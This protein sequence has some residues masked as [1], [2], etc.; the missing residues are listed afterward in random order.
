MRGRAFTLVEMLIAT[1]MVAILTLLLLA[2]ALGAIGAA[3]TLRCQN[4]LR[5][6][7]A[8][9]TQ[10]MDATRG[11]WPPILTTEVP[12]NLFGRIEAETGLIMAPARP[13]ADWGQPGP[14]WSIVLWPYLKSLDV[15][16]CPADPKAG[17]RG[18]DVVAPA[19]VHNVALLGAPPESYGQNVILFRTQ[20]DMRRKAGC[21]WGTAGDADYN[22][23]QSCTTASEQR[24]QFPAYPRLI[25]FFCGTSGMTL[26]SQYNI[27]WRTTGL[28]ERWEWHPR[29]ASAAFADE[30]GCGSNYLFADGSVEY[31]E[32]FPTPLEWGYDLETTP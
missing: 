2:A 6:I 13:A 11:V 20:D 3:N 32:D 24:R 4:H 7:G 25:L 19:K 5:H 15:Y 10:Y 16:T 22:G 8:A 14:H 23:L 29:R 31:R 27:A 28:V 26:G 17:R 21:S 12:T 9:Y 1:A 30:P 18:L